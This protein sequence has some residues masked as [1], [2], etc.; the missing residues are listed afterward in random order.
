MRWDSEAD[1]PY[2]SIPTLPD[3]RLTPWRESDAEQAVSS[4]YSGLRCLGQTL[5]RAE[6]RK[7]GIQATIPVSQTLSS[8]ARLVAAWLGVP[9][10][11]TSSLAWS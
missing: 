8:A 6:H 1:E 9:W 3:I 2:M 4:A 10:P 11:H 5:Q 7:M